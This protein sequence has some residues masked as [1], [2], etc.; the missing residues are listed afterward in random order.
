M[1]HYIENT[2]RLHKNYEN[3]NYAKS[4]K[5]QTSVHKNVLHFCMY[6]LT[7]KEKFKILHLVKITIH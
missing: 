7:H 4:N 5:P 1:I 2:H 6:I 3:Y